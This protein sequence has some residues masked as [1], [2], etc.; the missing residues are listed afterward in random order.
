MQ[1]PNIIDVFISEPCDSLFASTTMLSNVICW[2]DSTGSAIVSAIG[3]AE[4]WTYT[5]QW[6]NA[7]FG[8]NG[9]GEV[10]AQANSLWADTLSS[11]GPNTLWHTVTVTD[12]NGCTI[13]DSVDIKHLY[14]KIRPFYIN[15]LADTIWEIKFIE[16]SVSCFGLCDG[17]VSLETFG[18][19]LPHQYVWDV[20]PNTIIYNQPDTV[21]GLCAGGHDVLVQD[22]I[23]CQQRIRFGI[24]KPNQLFAVASE[25][26]PIS[27]FGLNCS[28][29]LFFSSISSWSYL[30]LGN[31]RF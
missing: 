28:R 17:E 29:G 19:V 15:A 14:K 11:T 18:G 26:S 30:Q 10:T 3:G 6:H 16:D 12:P 22:N 1:C 5:Y 4:P 8:I 2:G 25:V 7:P 23:G 9:I 31:S 24:D 13:E 27:C 21:D 20:N